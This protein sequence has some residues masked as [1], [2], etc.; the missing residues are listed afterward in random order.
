MAE[1]GSAHP[2]RPLQ[3]V[4]IEGSSY[5][6]AT[7]MVQIG[8]AVISLTGGSLDEPL[9]PLGSYLT[10]GTSLALPA[11]T[12][13]GA[14]TIDLYPRPG[15]TL[16]ADLVDR[17]DGRG[18]RPAVAGQGDQQRL[19]AGGRRRLR[20]GGLVLRAP[21]LRGLPALRIESGK[22][23]AVLADVPLAG[24]DPLTFS[25]RR[26]S[27][28]PDGRELD[29]TLGVEH[30][31]AVAIAGG[32]HQPWPCSPATRADAAPEVGGAGD[33]GP[34]SLTLFLPAFGRYR[35][36]KQMFEA[37]RNAMALDLETRE[38]LIDTVR[39]FVAER[40][41]LIEAKV[42]E[43]DADAGRGGRGDARAWGCS[44]CS[45]PEAFGGLG[46]NME[47]ECLVGIE[48]GRASPAFRSVFGTNVGIGSLRW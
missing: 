28:S 39:R 20:A 9:G 3:I 43:D 29:L 14:A 17:P 10:P 18:G 21:D 44:A 46:L 25:T 1:Q 4:E 6:S 36:L 2:R 41:R 34:R 31:F 13:F 12:R 7:G 22:F 11:R 48:L 42:A 27:A 8:D 30:A 35:L 23:Q 15:L 40:L 45:I 32:A 24:D 5:A 37:G 19:A 47:E 26:F 16:H 38:Q 33:G